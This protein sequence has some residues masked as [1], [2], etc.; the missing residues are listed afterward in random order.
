MDVAAAAGAAAAGPWTCPLC[1]AAVTPEDRA[2]HF[3]LERA[4]LADVGASAGAA[5]E[6]PDAHA[7]ASGSGDDERR[8]TRREAAWKARRRVQMATQANAAAGA[9]DTDE[10]GGGDPL[11][12][13]RS[14]PILRTPQHTASRTLMRGGNG[15]PGGACSY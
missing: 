11:L 8:P 6:G 9:S 10:A 15:V 1:A 14:V 2:A 12:R 4:R 3:E 5:A 7:H 13:A